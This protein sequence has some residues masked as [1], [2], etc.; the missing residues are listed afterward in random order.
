MGKLN[1]KGLTLNDLPGLAVT[2]LIVGVV[3]AIG[4][5]IS[6]TTQADLVDS[7][8]IAVNDTAYEALTSSMEAQG[9][10]ASYQSILAIVV[11]AAVLIGT[12]MA[13]FRV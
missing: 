8:D 7:G 12:I 2:F 9:K 10:L 11:V 5:V 6:S 1:K 4:V 3:A 13:S